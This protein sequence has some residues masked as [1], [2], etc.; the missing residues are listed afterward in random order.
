MVC[1]KLPALN[2]FENIYFPAENEE[3]FY[4]QLQNILNGKRCDKEAIDEACNTYSWEARL[5][6]M[7][8]ALETLPKVL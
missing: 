5:T 2:E 3:T 7:E 8:A 1:T 4:M 6:R